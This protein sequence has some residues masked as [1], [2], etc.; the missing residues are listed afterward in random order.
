MKPKSRKPDTLSA[1]L[2]FHHAVLTGGRTASDED[3]N[4]LKALLEAAKEELASDARNLTLA[5]GL[6][7][8]RW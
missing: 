2:D 1:A 4:A 6:P 8:E 3:W 5:A 7:L